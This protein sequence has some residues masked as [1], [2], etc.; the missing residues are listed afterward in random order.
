MIISGKWAECEDG[1]VRPLVQGFVLN[2]ESVA[3]PITF[4]LD[5]GADRTLLSAE[6]YGKLGL[7]PIGS[8]DRLSG[9]GGMQDIV[10][11]ETKIGFRADNGHLFIYGSQYCCVTSAAAIE[12]S[13]LGRDLLDIFAIVVDRQS[14]RIC[15]LVEGH[16]Y[17]ID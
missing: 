9:L 4:I 13:L 7:P 8:R 12:T 2:S 17:H 5:A 15:L 6:V 10:Q 3:V 1:F 14:D 16:P 11:V